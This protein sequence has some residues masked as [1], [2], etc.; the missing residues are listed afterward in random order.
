MTKCNSMQE[1]AELINSAEEWKLDFNEIIQQNGWIDE[2]GEDYGICSNGT[3]RLFFD[4]D[5][6][7]TL[8]NL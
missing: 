7:A 2:T 8:I 5:A 4:S 6:N 1:F 3:Q